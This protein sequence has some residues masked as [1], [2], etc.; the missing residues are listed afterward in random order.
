MAGGATC[1][2]FAPWRPSL[3][4]PRPPLARVPPRRGGPLPVRPRAGAGVHH[5]RGVRRG[6]DGG[7]FLAVW[8]TR[9]PRHR[10]QVGRP[11]PTLD[12]TPE[13]FGLLGS[14]PGGNRTPD[15]RIRSRSRFSSGNAPLERAGNAE[16]TQ[17]RMQLAVGG[18]AWRRP[19]RVQ[20]LRESA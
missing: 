14:A 3:A 1:C 19:R 13:T 4:F 17:W 2:P 18:A 20:R 8:S 9:G 11:S 10:K 12:E 16:V 15:L 7:E 6:A 5:L